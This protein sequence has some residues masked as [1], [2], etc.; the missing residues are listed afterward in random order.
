MGTSREMSRLFES[1]SEDERRAHAKGGPLPNVFTL[2]LTP[3]GAIEKSW[4]YDREAQA[5]ED[6]R[7]RAELG[8]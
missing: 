5:R 8:E 6:A 4:I 7:L 2:A 1:R 3:T